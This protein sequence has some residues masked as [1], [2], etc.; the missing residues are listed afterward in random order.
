SPRQIRIT[1]L[2]FGTTDLSI[3]TATGE[4]YTFRVQVVADLVLLEGKLRAMFPDTSIRLGQ[5]RDQ[6]VVEGQARSNTQISQI[7]QAIDSHLAWLVPPAAARGGIGQRA[8]PGEAANQ[9]PPDLPAERAVDEL[10]QTTAG[11]VGQRGLGAGQY[12]SGQ[13]VAVASAGF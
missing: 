7:L 4:T 5:I 6:V 1:G 11:V 8:V 3:T 9:Q 2:R 12:L 13:P 10:A